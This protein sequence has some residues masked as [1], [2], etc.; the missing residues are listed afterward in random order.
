MFKRNDTK[1]LMLENLVLII[2]ATFL[3]YF[4]SPWCLLMLAFCN[5]LRTEDEDESSQDDV[6]S[7]KL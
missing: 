1:W 4:V 6:S 3:A 2:C 5:Y 7:E